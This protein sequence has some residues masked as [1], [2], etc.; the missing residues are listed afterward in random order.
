MTVL[1]IAARNSIM[2]ISHYRH[3]ATE[4]GVTNQMELVMRGAD[5]RL[6]PIMMTALTTGLALVPLI[7]TGE[8]PGKKSSIV[9]AG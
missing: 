2:L 4:E 9:G 1:G 3:L 5:E 7:L 8:I 6:A